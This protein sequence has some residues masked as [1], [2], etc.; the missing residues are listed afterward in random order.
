[1]QRSGRTK[2]HLHTVGGGVR[3]RELQREAFFFPFSDRRV[4]RQPDVR[5]PDRK[6]LACKEL[7]CGVLMTL[8]ALDAPVAVESF[9]YS[10][11]RCDDA[12]VALFL[13]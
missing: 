4:G 10:E 13:A 11:P 7:L 5:L 6:D 8:Q 2:S 3:H 1:M 12:L 9:R